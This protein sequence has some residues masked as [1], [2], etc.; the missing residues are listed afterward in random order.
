MTNYALIILGTRV[1]LER[2]A[3]LLMLMLSFYNLAESDVL[4]CSFHNTGPRIK[5]WFHFL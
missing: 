4:L 1:Y 3:C 2:Q 5:I